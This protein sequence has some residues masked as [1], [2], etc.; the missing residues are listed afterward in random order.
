MAKPAKKSAPKK[1]AK[2]S[3]A[4][5]AGGGKATAVRKADAAEPERAPQAPPESPA[6]D[7]SAAA[8]YT[9]KPI[10]GVGWPAFRYPPQ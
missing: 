3:T 1:A 7:R 6:D 10:E 5:K 2:K 4:G 8:T 9:P